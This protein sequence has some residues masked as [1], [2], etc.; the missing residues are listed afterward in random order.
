MI[1]QIIE[2]LAAICFIT[3]SLLT[4]VAAIGLVRFPD[5]LSR[6]HAAT[7]PQVLGITL[8]MSGLALSFQEVQVAWKVVLVVALQMI[9]SPVSAH[10]VGRSGYR[11][12]KIPSDLL[13]VDEL[14]DDLDAAREPDSS[15]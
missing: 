8:L 4:L 6:M 15:S 13:I 11:T 7:K 1:D 12:K 9:S 5:L 10:L 2:V 3:G 14:R